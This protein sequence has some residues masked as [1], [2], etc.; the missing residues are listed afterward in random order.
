MSTCVFEKTI[1]VFYIGV[2][3]QIGAPKSL[4]LFCFHI[5]KTMQVDE[6][7]LSLLPPS[8]RASE[9]IC[10]TNVSHYELQVEIGNHSGLH[11]IDSSLL[12]MKLMTKRLLCKQVSLVT[13]S[14]KLN[15]NCLS[16]T[17]LLILSVLK[18]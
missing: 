7:T 3:D 16:Q 12:E 15:V 2:G 10:S 8:T 11:I 17:D 18:Q 9:V 5:F 4:Y 14:I 6:P 13:H 1:S